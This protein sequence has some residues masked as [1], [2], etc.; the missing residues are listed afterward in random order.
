VLLVWIAGDQPY[1]LN[2]VDVDA[3]AGVDPPADE[4]DGTEFFDA[5]AEE[6]QGDDRGH[7]RISQRAGTPA[8]RLSL[9]AGGVAADPEA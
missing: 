7:G 2:V 1:S 8:A 4:P 9:A 6:V 5:A 3:Q